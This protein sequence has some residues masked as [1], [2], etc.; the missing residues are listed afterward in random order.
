MLTSPDVYG[1]GISGFG[2]HSTS[3]Q[4]DMDS[5]SLSVSFS[6]PLSLSGL[7]EGAGDT[8]RRATG[9]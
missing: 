3:C 8:R 7:G 6:L 2:R 9:R 5:L 4:G 1:A